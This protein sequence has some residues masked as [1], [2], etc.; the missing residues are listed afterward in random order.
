MAT[1]YVLVIG[2]SLVDVML[3][4]DGVAE[5]PGGSPMNVAVGLARLGKKVVL[6]T[7]IG[8]DRRGQLIKDHLAQSGVELLPGSDQASHT[9]AADAFCDAEGNTSYEFDLEWRMPPLPDRF[10][11]DPPQ[12]VHTGSIAATLDPGAT[13]VLN[14]VRAFK[15][16]S[17]IS[18]DPNLRPTIV[19]P[20][21]A[22]SFLVD[23]VGLADIIKASTDD[24]GLMNRGN[25]LRAAASMHGSGVPMVVVTL[26]G[27]G[28]C[29]L[30]NS[31]CVAARGA[32]VASLQTA[33]LDELVNGGDQPAVRLVDTIGAGDAYM[34]G[35]LDGISA[36]GFF[37]AGHRSDISNLG[38]KQFSR[39]QRYATAA[40]GLCLSRAGA[41]PAWRSE[42][43]PFADEAAWSALPAAERALP[44]A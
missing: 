1:P 14:T 17:T 2:E 29:G 20:Q 12:L 28:S 5:R 32:N 16:R 11:E 22:I 27:V 38:E 4:P 44:K 8:Q 41:D 15:G 18:Y 37:G 31:A 10:F 30:T 36:L 21:I 40:S 6:A 39:L 23:Y 3:Y 7:W 43:P 13:D 33:S 25:G 34:A 35:L 42:L 9:S 19:S 24:L 26:G